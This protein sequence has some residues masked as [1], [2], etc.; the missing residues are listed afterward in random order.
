MPDRSVRE[1]LQLRNAL[2][3]PDRTLHGARPQRRSAL[4]RGLVAASL[5]S[6]I[7]PSPA[8]LGVSLVV[9]LDGATTGASD[10][11]T[12]PAP[13][14]ATRP[15][16]VTSTTP[17]STATRA[18]S[19]VRVTLKRVPTTLTWM[20]PAWTT[21]GALKE[22]GATSHTIPPLSS[23]ISM[24]C[25]DG[26]PSTTAD[27]GSTSSVKPST[28]RCDP[29]APVTMRE[30]RSSVTVSP[31]RARQRSRRSTPRMPE[32]QRPKSRPADLNAAESLAAPVAT[33]L[34]GPDVALR[35]TRKQR[36]LDLAQRRALTT[37]TSI[38]S[39][40]CSG[41]CISRHPPGL[42]L[43][44]GLWK[45]L[46]QKRIFARTCFERLPRAPHADSRS[47]LGRAHGV[48]DFAQTPALNCKKREGNALLRL[49]TA[50]LGVQ[51]PRGL[52]QK[53][54]LFG[55]RTVAVS[56]GEAFQY[57]EHAPCAQK[58]P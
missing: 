21:S 39:G 12:S 46:C 24:P 32:E 28:E 23:T 41:F 45:K 51:S 16:S 22:R 15:P 38:G 30:V 34:R 2:A 31:S 35:P 54:V 13:T 42:R 18:F 8:T 20:D 11:Q 33:P 27:S 56:V 25:S 50:E 48:S 1:R 29:F 9:A 26:L 14:R 10:G 17:C 4:R 6:L 58:K 19:P 57:W 53:R 7:G 47:Y 40:F 5:A 36:P 44:P 43:H 55:V 3:R 37:S 49:K 52:T